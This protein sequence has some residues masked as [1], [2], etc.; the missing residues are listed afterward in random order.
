MNAFTQRV[1]EALDAYIGIRIE[2][3]TFDGEDQQSVPTTMIEAA[4]QEFADA[5]DEL[6]NDLT[7]KAQSSSPYDPPGH[8]GMH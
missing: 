6:V 7:R 5:L 3:A 1:I 2:D 8:S 4:R